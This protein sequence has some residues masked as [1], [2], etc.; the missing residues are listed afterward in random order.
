MESLKRRE[1]AEEL[2]LRELEGQLALLED[3]VNCSICMERK[4]T[5]VFMCGH[6]TCSQCATTLK[7]CHI[8]R[9]GI[10]KKINLFDS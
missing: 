8:C 9:K 4:K 3:T 10:S 1:T 6:S 5:I 7:N 2:R